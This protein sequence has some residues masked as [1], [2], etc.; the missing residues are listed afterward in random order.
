[1]YEREVT[2][3]VDDDMQSR[4]A[5][6]DNLLKHKESYEINQGEELEHLKKL[7]AI[8]SSE[9]RSIETEYQDFLASAA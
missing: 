5:E 7:D 4:K 6:L 8:V 1:M 9:S 3:R 2:K